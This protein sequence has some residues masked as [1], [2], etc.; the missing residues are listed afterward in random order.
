MLRVEIDNNNFKD[1]KLFGDNARNAA[2]LL[3]A[4]RIISSTWSNKLKD[5]FLSMVEESVKGA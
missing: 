2:E 4:I 5:E 1:V 3:V